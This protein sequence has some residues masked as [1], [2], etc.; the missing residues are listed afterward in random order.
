MDDCTFLCFR[1]N[2][3]P[4][5][6]PFLFSLISL[7]ETSCSLAERQKNTEKF[8]DYKLVESQHNI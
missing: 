3:I 7:H 8:K 2:L 4:S 5:L 1:T 6:Y